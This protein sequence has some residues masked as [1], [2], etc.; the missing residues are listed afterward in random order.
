[1]TFLDQVFQPC[2]EVNA[3]Q[4]LPCLEIGKLNDFPESPV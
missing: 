2:T 3:H 4:L 1:M